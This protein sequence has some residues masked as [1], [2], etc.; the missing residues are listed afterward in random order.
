MLLTYSP[1]EIID[2][3]SISHIIV[4]QPSA[5][6]SGATLA[7]HI[8]WR[9]NHIGLEYAL[10]FGD[11]ACH[12]RLIGIVE[13]E[14]RLGSPL[15]VGAEAL[16]GTLDAGLPTQELEQVVIADRGGQG[17]AQLGFQSW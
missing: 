4:A 1:D 2:C 13:H 14:R 6:N 10:Q 3:P 8:L 7:N 9:N 11:L 16:G 15:P 17:V 12:E 5:Q